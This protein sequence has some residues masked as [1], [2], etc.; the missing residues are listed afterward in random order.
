[1]VALGID[2]GTSTTVAAIARGYQTELL[3]C[4][5]GVAIIPSVVAFTPNGGIEFGDAARARRTIDPANTLYSFKRIIGRKS[6]TEIVTDFSRRY[7]F[8]IEAGSD[9]WPRFVTR[10]GSFTATDVASQLIA[11][12]RKFPQ[13]SGL[14]L[15]SVRITVPATF[16]EAARAA[17]VEAGE[18]AGLTR[19]GL[20]DEPHAAVLPYLAEGGGEELIAVYDLGGGTFDVAVLACLGV[21]CEVIATAGD[22]YLGGDDIDQS[23]ADWVAD[24]VLQRHRWDI[25]TSTECY[26]KLLFA[27]ER[28]KIVLSETD[29]TTI[30]LGEIDEVLRGKTIDLERSELQ[31]LFMHL[32]QRTF[33][34]C[35]EAMA[36]SGLNQDDLNRVVMVGGGSFIP[37]IREGVEQYFNK[38]PSTDQPPNLVIGMGAALHGEVT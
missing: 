16:D 12:L 38:E 24:Q 15:D 29:V 21:D 7:P 22:V 8:E 25:R 17:T 37:I 32:L 1:M 9:G 26:Q 34:L 33:L 28:A 6:F 18:R 14:D 11:H 30:D 31:R 5:S 35:D 10:A 20:I 19:I 13:L 23:C 3:V 4:P 36:A 2:F 27:C